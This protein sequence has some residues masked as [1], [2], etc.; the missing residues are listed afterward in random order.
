[1]NGN[2]G[3][4]RA[5]RHDMHA[6]AERYR[7]FATDQAA[8]SSPTLQRWAEAIAEDTDLLALLTPLPPGKQQPNLVFAAA[9]WH[10][11][12]PGDVDSLRELLTTRWT[13]VEATIRARATQT[14]EAAR[15]AAILLSLQFVPGAVAL[16]EIGAAA[17]LCLIP[18]QYS[19]TFSGDV[20]LDPVSGP[21]PVSIGIHLGDGLKPPVAMPDISWRAGIDLNPLNPADPDTLAWLQTLIWPEHEARRTRLTAAAALA[22]PQ[23]AS[24]HQSLSSQSP[25]STE[26]TV[27]RSPSDANPAWY[28]RSSVAPR[29]R[30]SAASAARVAGLPPM[31]ETTVRLAARTVSGPASRA[32]G[33]S[34]PGPPVQGTTTPSATERM[35]AGSTPALAPQW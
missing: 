8:G 3:G 20:R 7:A 1:M 16:L 29:R 25:A 28:S 13:T 26:R 24:G 34:E 30:A 33:V 6:I 9:Q 21:S 11:A 2:T 14:N 10:G 22:R 18:D 4:H 17:G 19:Y 12:R 5:S 23:Q 27:E 35:C 15:C 31:P 32:K